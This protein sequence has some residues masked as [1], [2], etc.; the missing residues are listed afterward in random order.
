[1]TAL[2]SPGGGNFENQT[3]IPTGLSDVAAVAAGAWHT[4]AL[5]SDG[6]MVAWGDNGY[7][8]TTTPTGLTGVVAISTGTCHT[9]AVKDDGTV[10][11]WGSNDSNQSMVPTVISGVNRVAAGAYHTVALKSD[12]SVVGW[13]DNTY[14]Q[15]LVP[16]GLFGVV[17]VAAGS[18][19]TVAVKGDETVVA[20]GSNSSGQATVPTGLSGVVAVA[21][22]AYHTVALKGDGTV[23]AWGYNGNGETKVPGSLSGAIAVAAGSYHSVALKSGGTVVAWGDN[24]YGQITV[25][26]GLSGVVAVAAGWSHTVALKSNGTV[27]AWGDNSSGQST[28]PTGLSGVVAVA[29]GGGHSVAL[30][31]DGTVVTWGYNGYGQATVP[32]GLSGVIGVAAGWYHTVALKSDG[33]VVAWGDDNDGQSTTPTYPYETPLS[34]I[35]TWNLANL[36]TTFTPD[37]S[38]PSDATINVRLSQGI[39]SQNGMRLPADVIWSFT[40]G[41]LPPSVSTYLLRDGYVGTIYNQ[42]VSLNSGAS[43][44]TWSINSGNLPPGLSLNSAAGIIRG[45]PSTSGNFD[46]IVQ[47]VDSNNHVTSK[48]L[49]IA[50]NQALTIITSALQNGHV[51]VSYDVTVAVSGG[52]SPYSWSVSSG[53]LPTGLTLNAF[54][55]AIT[56]TPIATGN[57]SFTMQLQ[58]AN[59]VITTKDLTIIVDSYPTI[60]T[61]NLPNGYVNSIYNQVLTV[62]GGITPYFWSIVAGNLP[63]GLILDS[64]T[65]AI[66][67]VPTTAGNSSFTIQVKDVNNKAAGKL[68]TINIQ[69][70][71]TPPI[72]QHSFCKFV[73]PSLGFAL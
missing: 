7:G 59:N 40:T 37:V 33:T 44:I 21:A 65:G 8:Q 18:S 5:K 67:G 63:V 39:K 48:A 32:M 54:T 69:Q 3:S 22:G 41:G 31:S 62:T 34:G 19:H 58:D 57:N 60:S 42:S 71:N 66:T 43:P 24:S 36:T 12:G 30:K 28:V 25:P 14:N 4:V 10:V 16:T 68:L 53:L 13:G 20:W 50:V 72:K 27:V 47:A 26:S 38:L 2:W 11:A 17:A 73:I 52:K 9:V 70:I 29:A 64:N 23:V 55:G 49:S 56:G 61:S 46:F 15:T 45:T 1:M 51:G 35:L 6:T